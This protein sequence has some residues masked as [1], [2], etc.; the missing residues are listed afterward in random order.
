[1]GPQRIVIKALTTQCPSVS[2]GQKA[3]SGFTGGCMGFLNSLLYHPA[4]RHTGPIDLEVIYLPFHTGK[5]FPEKMASIFKIPQTRSIQFPDFCFFFFADTVALKEIKLEKLN[6]KGAVTAEEKTNTLYLSIKFKLGIGTNIKTHRENVS[7]GKKG[8][9][10]F[11]GLSSLAIF[12]ALS[13]NCCQVTSIKESC[14]FSLQIQRRKCIRLE[15]S[16]PHKVMNKILNIT[17]VRKKVWV[18]S[19]GT[20]ILVPGTKPVNLFGFIPSSRKCRGHPLL[21][22]L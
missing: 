3:Y 19:T 13:Q 5:D 10:T 18:D 7:T 4:A 14:L 6:F 2:P 22:E 8:W 16:W 12:P 11:K 21:K 9:L 15:R 17:Q 20:C 1:M